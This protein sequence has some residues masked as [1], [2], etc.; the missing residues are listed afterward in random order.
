MEQCPYCENDLDFSD[1]YEWDEVDLYKDGADSET[2]CPHCNQP[3]II[4]VS[5]SYDYE[6]KKPDCVYDRNGKHNIINSGFSIYTTKDI[7]IFSQHRNPPEKWEYWKCYECTKCDHTTFDVITKEQFYEE[8][9]YV[10]KDVLEYFA[11]YGF[12]PTSQF[13]P[14]HNNS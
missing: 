2:E 14:N 5:I 13:G 10:E 1:P 6:V 12:A 3:I 4:K 7:K 9:G 11:K 8:S